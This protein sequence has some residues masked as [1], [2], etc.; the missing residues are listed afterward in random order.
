MVVLCNHLVQVRD[1]EM[2]TLKDKNERLEH[3]N[4]IYRKGV[5]VAS[6]NQKQLNQLKQEMDQVQSQNE[7]MRKII[8]MH[9]DEMNKHKSMENNGGG[10]GGFGGRRGP[11]D[12]F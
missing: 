11:T 10:G 7:M 8:A 6:D 12:A 4:E 9:V 2:R 3:S 5:K 1:T